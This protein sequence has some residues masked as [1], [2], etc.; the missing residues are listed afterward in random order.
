MNPLKAFLNFLRRKKTLHEV[1][2]IVVTPFKNGRPN[3]YTVSFDP[4]YDFYLQDIEVD[5]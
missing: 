4:N 3:E 5:D 2:R 1:T